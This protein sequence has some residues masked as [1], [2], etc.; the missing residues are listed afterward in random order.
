MSPSSEHLAVEYD[1]PSKKKDNKPDTNE[2]KQD[3]RLVKMMEELQLSKFLPLLS[4][5]ELDYEVLQQLE[6]CCS[7]CLHL[8]SD[9]WK[10]TDLEKIGLPLGPRKKILSYIQKQSGDFSCVHLITQH[11]TDSFPFEKDIEIGQRLGGGAFGIESSFRFL[12]AEIIFR[13]CVSRNVARNNTSCIE[14]TS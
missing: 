1:N 2:V 5:E 7:L 6:V 10:E 12:C 11:S 13:R 9:F 14:E 3:Q 4:K 8:L